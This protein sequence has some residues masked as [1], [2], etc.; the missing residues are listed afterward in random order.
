MSS[1]GCC[2]LFDIIHSVKREVPC[3]RQALLIAFF[4]YNGI[5]NIGFLPVHPSR[6]GVMDICNSEF[7]LKSLDFIDT[8]NRNSKVGL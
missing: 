8:I 5:V 6:W 1:A 4:L 3:T 7:R 2:F